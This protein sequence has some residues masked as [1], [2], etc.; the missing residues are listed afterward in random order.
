MRFSSIRMRGSGLGTFLNSLSSDARGLIRGRRI[1]MSGTVTSS[2]VIA[3]G[4]R[5][6]L[7]MK[8]D[9]ALPH[10]G[11]STSRF[12]TGVRF[13]TCVLARMNL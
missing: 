11:A 3:L 6:I 5:T 8:S 2:R 12:G 1:G 9:G 4:T 10:E 7:L 13:L